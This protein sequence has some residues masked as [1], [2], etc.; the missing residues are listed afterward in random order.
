MGIQANRTSTNALLPDER[1]AVAVHESGHA[2][3]ATLLP[4]ADPVAKVTILAAG[5]PLGVTEQLPED[6]HHLSP[7]SYLKDSLAA[8][9]G[10]RAAELLV[11]GEPSSGTG[12]DLAGATE[13]ATR[14]VRD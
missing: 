6:E 5:H 3:V 12:S 10:G 1:R 14:M 8:R 11:L 4:H 7:E 9:L 2:L 13:L